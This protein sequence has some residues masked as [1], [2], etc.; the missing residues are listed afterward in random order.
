M[1]IIPLSEEWIP[2]VGEL[3]RKCF[4]QPWSEESLRE[5]FENPLFSFWVACEGDLLVGYGGA[6]FAGDEANVT[7]IAVAKEYRGKGYGTDI[8]RAL[9]EE[10]KR[11]G[12]ERIF[13]EVRVGNAAAIHVYEKCG[14]ERK[15]VRKNFYTAPQE[16][17][18]V[19]ALRISGEET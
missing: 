9:I 12:A 2:K 5:V 11:R 13:L 3:E 4:S 15:G 16:D 7:N 19:Y 14:F 8:V 1:S 17:G 10:A 18:Y 6:Y